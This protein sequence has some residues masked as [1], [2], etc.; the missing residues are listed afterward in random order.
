MPVSLLPAWLAAT[1]FTFQIYFDFSGYTD[2]ALGAAR[3]FGIRLPVNFNSPLRSS[4]II[5]FWL[6]WHV[7]L[8]RF[9]TAY[10]YNPIAL[11]LTRRRMATGRAGFGGRNTTFGTFFQLLLLPTV[12]TMFIS[13]IWHG[14]GYLFLIWGL[15]HGLYLTLNH[16]WR[17]VAQ[18][19]WPDSSL[20]KKLMPS[21]GFV[22][23]FVSVAASMVVFRSTSVDTATNILAGMAGLNGI[24]LPS[25]I[26][27]K[28]SSIGLTLS[29]MN[30][31]P[32]L[33]NSINVRDLL[34]WLLF[35]APIA[36]LL[37]NTL[38]ILDRYEPAI[39]VKASEAPNLF[40]AS[41]GWRPSLLW[42]FFVGIVAF[43]AIANVGGYTEFLYWQF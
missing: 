15:M 12:V 19:Y 20:Y 1:G 14:A 32:N 24:E 27:D 31:S 7:S 39:G 33:P 38:Q 2:M 9:L 41:I 43:A 17:L 36:L 35:M 40:R 42:A 22:L 5:D 34:A 18:R 25:F 13:G 28:L 29:A 8:T 30:I 11:S 4:S 23:T 16:G 26:F 37:P 10:I 6:R 3:L 21:V